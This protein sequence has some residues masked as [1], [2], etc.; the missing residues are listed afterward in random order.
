[1]VALVTFWKCRQGLWRPPEG[2]RTAMMVALQWGTR[3]MAAPGW[4]GGQ[5]PG[6]GVAPGV[7]GGDG[8][9]GCVTFSKWPL[10]M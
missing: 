6:V 3:V 9:G 7:G 10:R 1:M 5:N 8:S 2:L 4:S